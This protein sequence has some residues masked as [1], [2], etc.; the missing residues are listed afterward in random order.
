MNFFRQISQKPWL[1]VE[2][3][4]AGFDDYQT[5][6]PPARVALKMFLI[7]VGI[8]FFLLTIAYAGRMA[9]EE[10]RPVPQPWLMWQNTV[11]LVLASAALQWAKKSAQSNQWTNVQTALLAAGALTIAFLV[12]QLLSWQQL[13]DM[14]YFKLTNPA[15]ALFLMIT[16]LHGLHMLGGLIAWG[17]TTD[18][19]W[20]RN[21]LEKTKVRQSVENCTLYWHVLLV[22]WLVMF[23]LLFSGNNTLDILLV[24]CGIK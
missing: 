24:L 15:I 10:L 14:G 3:G 22:V 23:G 1:P 13:V 6:T 11:M 2:E 18:K 19:V 21:E 8:L 20:R 16:G 7:V 17:R 12:G 9:F 5:S 4:L